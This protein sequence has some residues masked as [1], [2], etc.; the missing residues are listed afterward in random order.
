MGEALAS[1][2]RVTWPARTVWVA[3]V[4]LC[5]ASVILSVIAWNDFAPDDLVFNS[6]GIFSSLLYATIGL[7][8]TLRARNVI[9]WILMFAGLALAFVAF[10]TTYVAVGL[11][12]SP[13]SL[14]APREVAAVTQVLWVPTMVSLAVMVLLFPTGSLP[15][16][17][18]RPVLWTAI[19]GAA[20][21]FLLLAVNPGHSSRIRASRSRT[22]WASRAFGG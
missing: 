21:G 11:L 8:I 1:T 3:T 22:P 6:L 18:W 10:G 15:S 2:R 13:G 5:I 7:L 12:T 20:V 14:P 17:R 4:L 19:A 16:P 9:G